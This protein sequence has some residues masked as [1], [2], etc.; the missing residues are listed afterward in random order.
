MLSDRWS[1]NPRGRCIRFL[2]STSIILEQNRRLLTWGAS[3]L[4]QG[5]QY[6]ISRRRLYQWFLFTL[7]LSVCLK[8]T[9]RGEFVGTY[10]MNESWKSCFFSPTFTLPLFLSRSLSSVL[11]STALMTAPLAGA[12]WLPINNSPNMQ[13][14]RGEP[15]EPLAVAHLLSASLWSAGIPNT[16]HSFRE[17]VAWLMHVVGAWAC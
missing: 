10:L 14:Q 12:R 7:F 16:R 9:S 3:T 11:N 5:S 8:V 13:V 6:G 2:S 17:S 15:D 4:F 1:V